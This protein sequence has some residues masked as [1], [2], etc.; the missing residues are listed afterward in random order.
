MKKFKKLNFK[1]QLKD[2]PVIITACVMVLLLL[3]VL[4]GKTGI[5]NKMLSF[6]DFLDTGY[7]EEVKM[8]SVV[9]SGFY[10]DVAGTMLLEKSAEWTA[11]HEITL[12]FDF[13]T[14]EIP[15][16]VN[17]DIIIVLDTSESMK[18]NGRVDS[19]KEA[20]EYLVSDL[21]AEGTDNRMAF[22]TFNSS[23]EIQTDFTSDSS[24]IMD[25]VN[26]LEIKGATN[27]YLGLKDVETLLDNYTE[28]SNTDVHMIFITDGYPTEGLGLYEAQY[29][30]LK[31]K[32]GDSLGFY[33]TGIQFEMGENIVQPVARIS[34]YQYYSYKVERMEEDDIKNVLFDA[35][36]A[37][38]YYSSISLTDYVYNDYF[39]ID[40]NQK[41][42]V[43]FGNVEITNNGDNQK[44]VWNIPENKVKSGTIVDLEF[45]VKAQ[46]KEEYYDVEAYFPTNKST[47]I[48]AAASGINNYSLTTADTP[49]LQSWYEVTYD[50]NIPAG[51]S[52]SYTKSEKYF[53]FETVSISNDSLSCLNHQFKGWEVNDEDAVI[54][55]DENFIMP[56]H[57]ALVGARWTSLS[58]VKSMSG[59]I[60]SRATLYK[61]LS[62]YAVMDNVA[63]DYVTNSFGI[64]LS[65]IS[66]DTNGKGLYTIAS[67]AT[68]TYPIHYFR[69]NVD[70]NNLIF[71]GFCW[72]IIR[73][74]E[75]GGVKL[76]YNGTP[77]NGQC[78]AS[79]TATT[80]GTSAYNELT[81]GEHGSLADVG[82]MYGSMYPTEY[83]KL[84]SEYWANFVG[85]Y[86]N[87][88]SNSS[89]YFSTSY[90]YASSYI[91][92]NASNGTKA[93]KV[94]GTTT[95]T[96]I[97]KDMIGKYTI[98]APGTNYYNE[99]LYYVYGV[100]ETEQK[101][102]FI[103]FTRDNYDEANGQDLY[104]YFYNKAL[105]TEWVY[106]NDVTYDSST[107]LYTLVDTINLKPINYGD[108]ISV[109]NGD[110]KYHYTCMEDGAT[111]CS[112]VKYVFSDV[113]EYMMASYINLSGGKKI[114]DAVLEMVGESSN[115]T[116]STVKTAVDTWFANNLNTTEYLSMIEDTVYCNER[117]V[118]VNEN[119]DYHRGWSKDGLSTEH[120]YY[121]NRYGKDFDS[122]DVED[123]FTVSSSN[124]NGK[125]TYPVGLLTAGEVRYAGALPNSSSVDNTNFYIYN[126]LDNWLLTPSYQNNL[127]AHMTYLTSRGRIMYH[128]ILETIYVRPVISL[129]NATYIA[130]GDG[131]TLNPYIIE[132]S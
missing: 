18:E 69:G 51:C 130:D 81:I 48:E 127:Y 22:I 54:I 102:Y 11:K 28:R 119:E 16:N 12:K 63:S 74:T 4:L 110:T 27:Y 77:S 41:V 46:L 64:S 33:A 10:N 15:R 106:G 93:F 109:V 39:T 66:S 70:N 73:T 90:Y 101:V 88:F 60:N 36:R 21:F 96:T 30:R 126:G 104:T 129:R 89:K 32:F 43:H 86:Q 124:G 99:E 91:A 62:N 112:E 80:I 57:D 2:K 9:D 128:D 115:T 82:Y 84:G 7:T 98:F 17:R 122:C 65:A 113:E 37:A 114:E 49:V 125:L 92:Y 100:D 8:I 42:D 34:D 3:C 23:S 44:V 40:P 131:S 76:L 103:R 26:N 123:S 67:T 121:A 50:A 55:N 58:L 61:T 97:S 31:D 38:E 29:R 71:G 56:G 20:F 53:P 116:N 68:D 120:L 118:I 85:A 45:E 72:K 6:G 95:Y 105:N 59:T 83:V 47:T 79:G 94:S 107:G 78:V 5:L 19:I 1:S 117:N 24:T 108:N 111:Q 13:E 35:A 132:M 87:Y 75:T 52:T 14:K 25:I